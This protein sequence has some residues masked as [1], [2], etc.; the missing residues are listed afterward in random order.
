MAAIVPTPLFLK[1]AT[2]KFG[3]TDTYEAA[4]RDIKFTPTTSVVTT[5]AMTPTAI[6]QDVEIAS[7]TVEMT[8][9]QDWA[10]G[11]L[12]RYLM[13]NE[14]TAVTLIFTPISGGVTVTAT[15]TV[16]PGAIGGAV[17]E[18]AEST[19]TLPSSKPVLA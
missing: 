6:Y 18:Y 17:G 3:A 19:I 11:S 4:V 13:T 1:N 9:L 10:V 7:W 8:F 15:V 12:G 5:R 2:V 14:G 16:S